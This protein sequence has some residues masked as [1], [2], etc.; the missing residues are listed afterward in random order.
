MKQIGLMKALGETHKAD[1]M[2]RDER[3]LLRQKRLAEHIGYVKE[4]SPFF[5]ELYSGISPESPLD[6]FPVTNKLM[7]MENYD[8]W[9]TDR[10]VTL[11]K[12]REFMTDTDNV[13][14]KLDGKYLVFSTSGS[15]GNPCIVL[16]D[17]SAMNVSSAIGVIRS[18]S[19]GDVMKRFIKAGGKSA[20][21]FADKGF[22]L[23][24]G[25]VRYQ[26]KRMP[27]KKRQMMIADVRDAPEKLN[28]ALNAFQ[29]A[30]LGIYP[31]AAELLADEQLAGRLKINPV[32]IMT[33]GEYLS[34]DVRK[35]LSEVF[36]CHV[37]TNYSCTEG[38]TM[39]CECSEQHF[40]INDDWIIIE[41]VDENNKP[42]PF[43]TQS[44]KLLLTN[45]ENKICPII[46]FE[47]T[48]RVILHNELCPCG[49]DR[50]WLE[51]EGRTDDILTFSNGVRIAPLSVYAILKEVH[52]MKRFQL[53]K[54]SEDVL[55]LRIISEDKQ[56]AFKEA[57]AALTKFLSERGI[58]AE[59]ILSDKEPSANPFSGKFKH[60]IC[61]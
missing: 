40:H 18:F 12:V 23:G 26:I 60:I 54:K 36:K 45:L 14:R 24:C 55:E 11:E 4:N 44:A 53:V 1:K 35:H 22:Y 2:S 5:S 37:Q 46:R 8:R 49:N 10:S 6:A 47:I 58:N 41:A 39:A 32:L 15:T 25:S 61:K 27:W 50:P 7:L 9:H 59:I 33:G 28:A 42:V 29:P 34:G 57:S 48:D 43:G 3:L 31:T 52:G 16:Y 56:G 30:M 13:G 38:G 17:D 21:V 20:A 19:D 51:I